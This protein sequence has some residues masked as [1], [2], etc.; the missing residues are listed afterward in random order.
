MEEWIQT[1]FRKTGKDPEHYPVFAELFT[2]VFDRILK[3]QKVDALDH[4]EALYDP[5]DP[6]VGTARQVVEEDSPQLLDHYLNC[7]AEKHTREFARIFARKVHEHCDDT[8]RALVDA[9]EAIRT[10]WECDMSNPAYAEACQV[11]LR[12]E[13]SELFSNKCAEFL[14]EGDLDLARAKEKATNYEEAVKTRLAKG[15]SAERAH[16]CAHYL[17]NEGEEYAEAYA[18]VCEERLRTGSSIDDARNFAEIF[19][20][21]LSTI[22]SS[23]WEEGEED[24]SN[25]R[26]MVHA[27]GEW[28]TRGKGFDQASYVDRFVTQ[29][30]NLQSKSDKETSELLAE[31]EVLTDAS[32][33]EH[34]PRKKGEG[35]RP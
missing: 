26:T 22:G 3:E 12:N 27:E 33:Q 17:V 20:S 30:F 13:R 29:F 10:S 28:R 32:M 19:V 11:C 35:S 6:E 24:G 8:Q 7:I 9:F 23:D 21:H 2:M 18:R 14:I 25:E 1:E 16:A 34:P 4:P 5:R 31:A 15:Y